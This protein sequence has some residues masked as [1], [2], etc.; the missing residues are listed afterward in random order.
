MSG[1]PAH[2]PRKLHFHTSRV[3][4]SDHRRTRGQ[5]LPLQDFDDGVW[6]G[7]L[8]SGSP[9]AI[10][11]PPPAS[12]VIQPLALTAPVES[13]GQVS[14]TTLCE[15]SAPSSAPLVGGSAYRRRWSIQ[16]RGFFSRNCSICN[17][18]KKSDRRMRLQSQSN[19]PVFSR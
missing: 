9:V 14:S 18:T 17:G 3:F 1:D 16:S 4:P 8:L 2:L 12:P 5:R 6:V 15:S 10:P 11:D 13:P 19:L 7:H